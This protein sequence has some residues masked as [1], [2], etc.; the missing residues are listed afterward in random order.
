MRFW[1]LQAIVPWL[2]AGPYTT[3][4]SI[5]V[6][7]LYRYAVKGLSADELSAVH[8]ST[9]GE[10]FP[11]DRRFALL[12]KAK[13]DKFNG[14]DWLHK[15][16]FLCAFTDPALMASLHSTYD[17]VVDVD[18]QTRRMLQIR[19][20]TS[21]KIL[22]EPTD[23]STPEGR[24]QLGDLLSTLSGQEVV[25]VTAN[26]VN[27]E[28]QNEPHRFQF[29]NT[30]SGYKQNNG[31]TRTIHVINKNTVDAVS[32]TIGIPLDPRRFRP[33][34]VIDG[35]PPFAEFD[36]VDNQQSLL[37][38]DGRGR[39][40]ALNRTVRCQGISLD[41]FDPVHGSKEIDIPGLLTKHFPDT[42]PFLG[43]YASIDQAPLSLKLGAMN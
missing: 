26:T 16:N 24:S 36:W 14:Q 41:P 1:L 33:N 20:R 22:L 43:I 10:T 40:R 13:R 5:Q 15:E 4:L 17:I 21:Q 32:K 2:L 38:P 3:A 37:T 9:A 42:G 27:K 30:S 28:E 31:D 12:Y 8:L 34:L 18:G 25:C 29:G 19:D 39:L 23:L 35:P 7:G 6:S 11:D